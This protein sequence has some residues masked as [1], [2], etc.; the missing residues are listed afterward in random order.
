MKNGISLF[1]NEEEKQILKEKAKEIGI[2][3][4]ALIREMIKNIDYVKERKSLIDFILINQSLLKEL[5]KIGI[6]INQIALSLNSNIKQEKDE[7]IEEIK[8]L[9]RLLKHFNEFYNKNMGVKIIKGK[10]SAKQ[11][12]NS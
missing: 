6:N 2:T 10:Y 7:I 9:K 11:E 12:N 4:S 3:R 5:N 8:E 1:L